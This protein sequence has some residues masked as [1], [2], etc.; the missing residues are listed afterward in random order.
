MASVGTTLASI[1]KVLPVS[2]NG[3][4]QDDTGHLE[5]Q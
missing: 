3:N 4:F 5:Q 1:K 2:S